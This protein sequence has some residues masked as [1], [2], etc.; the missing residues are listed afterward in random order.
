MVKTSVIISPVIVL[1]FG[2]FA[3]VDRLPALPPHRVF[4]T[5]VHHV[6]AENIR[7]I[8]IW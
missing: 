6:F 2:A 1:L 3:R 8:T 4:D 7:I 5:A